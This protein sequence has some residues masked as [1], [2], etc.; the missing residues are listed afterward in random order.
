MKTRVDHYAK[1]LVGKTIVSVRELADSE[2]EVFGWYKSSN[3]SAII[4]FTD[5]TWACVQ[6]DPEGNGPG[7]L[8]IGSYLT[9]DDFDK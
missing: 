2:Y 8:E 9:A 7:F 6:C 4:E 1:E 3:P 5:G